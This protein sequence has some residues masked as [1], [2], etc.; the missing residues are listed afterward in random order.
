M[1]DAFLLFLMSLH[2]KGVLHEKTQ[3]Q[4]TADVTLSV[5]EGES[6]TLKSGIRE[7]Q[8]DDLTVWTFG[9]TRIAL[10]NKEPGKISLFDGDDGMFRN[11]LH[12]NNQTGDL[13]ITNITTEHTGFYQLEIISSGVLS[14]RFTVTVS[15]YLPV[16]IVT[17]VSTQNS[18]L[19]SKCVLLCSVMN[20]THVSL[21]WYKGKSL[22][23]S[24]SVSDLN[25]RLSLPLEVEYQDTNTYRCVVNNPITNHTQHL[26]ITHVCGII[27]PVHGLHPGYIVLMCVIATALAVV[28]VYCQ[29]KSGKAKHNGHPDVPNG[30]IQLPNYRCQMEYLVGLIDIES[31][32]LGPVSEQ[33]CARTY[34]LSK[35]NEE[36]V[37][38]RYPN[39][40]DEVDLHSD[41][42]GEISEQENCSTCTGTETSIETDSQSNRINEDQQNDDRNIEN[43]QND[44]VFV[45][46][47]DAI[48]N[49]T[50]KE[51]QSVTLSADV[52]T[53]EEDDVILWTFA[54]STECNQTVEFKSIAGRTK[55]N[56]WEYLCGYERFRDRLQ[57]D[58]QTGSLTITNVRCV[59]AGLYK[60]CMPRMKTWKTFIVAVKVSVYHVI[61]YKNKHFCS[62]R[63]YKS[64]VLKL[65]A[66]APGGAPRWIQGATDFV[67]FYEI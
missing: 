39:N 5:M 35:P 16:P 52:T 22:L 64:V 67:A 61:K 65:G 28:G 49:L 18:S 54:E 53:I 19:I 9:D 11:K 59:D 36:D 14:K 6:P 37:P 26:N 62:I 1:K 66:V 27:P 34:L 31:D 63:V 32:D 17:K 45:V 42:Q 24:I 8:R 15:A 25:I 51:G 41:A 33:C 23:S 43:Q 12:L 7:I 60:L 3:E 57:L 21:S 56:E 47:T 20:V 4:K 2:V 40:E 48:R 13:T 58:N 44:D 10:M 50:V 30:H 46:A 55:A 38:Q 29:S